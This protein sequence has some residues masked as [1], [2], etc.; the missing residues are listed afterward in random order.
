MEFLKVE[1]GN[2]SVGDY[3]AKFEELAQFCPYAELEMD[4]RSKCAKF[5]S[6]LKPKLKSMFGHQEIIDFPTL[7]NKCS[8]YEDDFEADEAATSR[9][10][11]PKH[12]GPQRNFP[13]GKGKGK[14]FH[15]E[16]KPYSP[17]TGN[18]SYPSH[19]SR[20]HAIAGGSR[21]NS[22]SLCNKCGRTH[23]GD[24]CPGMALTCFH[25]KEV[26][27]IRRHCPKLPQSVNA[28][29]VERP[30]STGRVFT[31]SGAEASI[32]DGLIKGFS[33]ERELSRLGEKW[34][35][36]AVETVRFSLMRESLA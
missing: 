16:R 25:C 30:R 28:V 27:H 26:G 13:L 32:V 6:G 34:H 8:V 22:P 29:R 15:E 12:F 24:S 9:V 20:T 21:L 4:G 35:F 11:P 2:M 36:G 19:G 1:Q 5:E 33:L 31:M 23:V 17:P 3:A 10:V 7:V 18:R 14:A